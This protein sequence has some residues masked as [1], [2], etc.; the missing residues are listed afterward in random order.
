[1]TNQDLSFSR[2]LDVDELQGTVPDTDMN[3]E[4]KASPP[5]IATLRRHNGITTV[6][7][8]WSLVKGKAGDIIGGI[9]GQ[10]VRVNA[11]TASGRRPG[12]AGHFL[13]PPTVRRQGADPA[14][15][16][17]SQTRV[18]TFQ[19]SARR[20]PQY[21]HQHGATHLSGGGRRTPRWRRPAWPVLRW[22]KQ[23]CLATA[24]LAQDDLPGRRPGW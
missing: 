19:A 10:H 6:A 18:P 14:T 16:L 13:H 11:E 24:I 7:C 8:R 1:L 12:G 20:L 3:S 4:A 21:S 15:P 22:P 17:E 2:E 23:R 9:E 5:S